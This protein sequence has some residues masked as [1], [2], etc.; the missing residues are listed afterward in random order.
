MKPEMRQQLAQQSFEEKIRKVSELVQLSRKMK[1]SS[2]GASDWTERLPSL[3]PEKAFRSREC[4]N[5][6]ATGQKN[7]RTRDEAG[8]LG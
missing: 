6:S 3:M 5:T 1:A 8:A 4:A 7:Q 2:E